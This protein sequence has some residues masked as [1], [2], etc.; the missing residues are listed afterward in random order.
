MS[1]GYGG[2]YGYG[3]GGY[4]GTDVAMGMLAGAALGST[5]GYAW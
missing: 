4:S 5:L 3:R 1:K 2:G